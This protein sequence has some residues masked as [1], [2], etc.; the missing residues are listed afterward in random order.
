MGHQGA[1]ECNHTE[2]KDDSN[3]HGRNEHEHFKFNG[4]S[5]EADCSAAAGVSSIKSRAS[6]YHSAGMPA[7]RAAWSVY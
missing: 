7:L 2:E 5:E 1:I 3:D 6:G 4:I